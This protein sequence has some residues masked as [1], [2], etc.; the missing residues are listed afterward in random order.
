[1][2]RKTIIVTAIGVLLGLACAV[3][4]HEGLSGDREMSIDELKLYAHQGNLDAQNKLGAAYF[5]GK[6]TAKN[7]A[8]A[9][10]GSGNRLK[11]DMP[12]HSIIWQ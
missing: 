10:G 9:T 7:V 12:S 8:E 2:K 3:F 1:M 11:R 4:V 5:N 6:G